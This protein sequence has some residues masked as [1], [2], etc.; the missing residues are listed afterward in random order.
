MTDNPNSLEVSLI[1]SAAR[2]HA[3]AVLL[4]LQQDADPEYL[5]SLALT[6][7]AANG[8]LECVKIL[9]PISDTLADNSEALCQAATNG[10]VQC[11]EF[12]I[13]IS[14]AAA[15]NS[16]ALCLAARNGH[17]ECVNALIPKAEPLDA[18]N[19]LC[20]A[21]FEGHPECVALLLPLSASMRH[22]LNAFCSAAECGHVRVAELMLAHEPRISRA[23]DFNELL[24]SAVARG[25]HDLAALFSSIIDKASL[26][27]TVPQIQ[28]T[29]SSAPSPRL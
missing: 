25:H 16:G 20:I 29:S 23:L 6:L 24:S 2:G 22:T 8:H 3:T 26:S 12:L 9:A 4:L 7:A 21:A 13:P 10:H 1:R 27:S 17:V 15:E 11:V 14:D 28:K 18:T 5:N 19:A